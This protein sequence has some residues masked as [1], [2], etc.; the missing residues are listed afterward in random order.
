MPRNKIQLSDH[1]TY[2]RL[3]R[4][5]LPTVLM[6]CVSSLYSIVDA[7]FVSNYAGKEAF[8]AVNLIIPLPSLVSALGL[9]LG[10]GGCAVVSRTLGEGDQERAQRYFSLFSYVGLALGAIT[11]VVGVCFIRQMAYALGARGETLEMCVLYGTILFLGQPF[12]QMQIVVSNF[13]VTAEKPAMGLKVTLASGLVNVVLD[14]LFIAVL[15]WGVTGA[16]LATIIGQ[17]LGCMVSLIYFGRKNS[18]LL[19][20]VRTRVE[21]DVLFRTCINGSSELLLNISASLVNIAYNFQ[22]IRLVGDDGIAAYGAV[23][24]ANYYFSALIFG[25]SVAS[26]PG[27]GFHYG[28]KNHVELKS[29]FRKSLVITSSMGVILTAISVLFAG[30]AVALFSGYDDALFDMATAG[31]RLYAPAFLIMGV[32]VWASGFFTALGN[33]GISALISCMRTIIFQMGAVLVL[34]AIMGMDGIW[35]AAAVAEALTLICVSWLL[36]SHKDHYH[37]A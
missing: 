16:A 9:M 17:S 20:L 1:F 28:A 25:Y 36:H 29:L 37:Y 3:F 26:A 23:M 11:C 4:F 13:Y 7:Y 5:I 31:F 15:H 34:P 19:R 22:L 12:H 14:Y 10:A 6:M 8:A 32:N 21:W 30:P 35:I 27:V 24:Y 18:S 2:G 33:G